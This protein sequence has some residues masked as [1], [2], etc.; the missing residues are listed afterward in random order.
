MSNNKI[1]YQVD[2]H[3]TDFD[4][5]Y[6]WTTDHYPDGE[7]MSSSCIQC[8]LRI[9]RVQLVAEQLVEFERPFARAMLELPESNFYPEWCALVEHVCT[10]ACEYDG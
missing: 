4:R 3:T 5:P 2:R 6:A 8:G 10:E 1:I 7:G 9:L